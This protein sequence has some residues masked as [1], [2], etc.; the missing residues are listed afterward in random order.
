MTVSVNLKAGQ[1]SLRWSGGGLLVLVSIA[2]HGVL[3]G[4]PLPEAEPTP[5]A[6]TAELVDP[7]TVA[8]VRLPPAPKP[9]AEP[10]PQPS[11]TVPLAQGTQPKQASPSPQASASPASP[12]P[13]RLPDRLPTPPPPQTLDERLH[14]PAAYEFNQQAKGLVADEVTL[15]TT[16]ISDWLE[17]EA[18]GVSDSDVPELG[19]KLAPLQ[20][21]YPIA[22]CLTPPPGEGLVG[23][24]VSPTGELVKDP[25]LLDSTGY[26][27]LDDKALEMARQ[28]TFAPATGSQPN[29]SA[30]WL[31][32]EVQYDTASCPP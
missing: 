13:D 17:T 12:E 19:R 21:T 4:V 14:D 16:V 30:H 32:I 1:R 6:P 22:T 7:A 25:V 3:L 2:L 15:L 20:V 27:V 18:Q 11:P 26:D 8:V 5:P 24:I 10:V 28:Q 23:V 31:P 9:A 29:P